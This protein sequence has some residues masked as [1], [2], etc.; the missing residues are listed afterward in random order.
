[1]QCHEFILHAQQWMEGETSAAAQAHLEACANCRS[2]IADLN[3]IR[4]AAAE[5]PMPEPPERIWVSVR[6]QLA[7]EGVIREETMDVRTVAAARPR[8]GFF[9]GLRPAMAAV[10]LTAV[11][12]IA[13]LLAYDSIQTN[14]QP[15]LATFTDSLGIPDTVAQ[16]GVISEIHEH[17]PAVVDSY[18]QNLQIVDNFI[19]MCE[20]TVKDEPRNETAREYLVNA[21][22]QK[23][24]L[25]A[26]I[27]ERGAMGD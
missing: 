24:E 14:P 22:Q 9:P 11:F 8:F 13:G 3:A 10:Y 20:K 21:Y 2:L 27:S 5:L 1:M 26:Q 16:P 4:G 23:A 18:K 19:A 25:L 7:A 17:N 6:N 15:S 12:L